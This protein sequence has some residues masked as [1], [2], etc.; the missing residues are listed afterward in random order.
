MGGW[1]L[2]T[3]V[4]FL[5]ISLVATG[6]RWDQGTLRCA[7]GGLWVWSVEHWAFPS[8]RI[9]EK[10]SEGTTFPMGRWPAGSQEVEAGACP[11]P[12]VSQGMYPTL[13]A[14]KRKLPCIG[15]P[16]HTGNH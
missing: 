2:S 8:Q 9:R 5:C 16:C 14:S 15:C 13:E 6:S 3:R 11:A 7:C 4:S 12:E 10:G 1:P